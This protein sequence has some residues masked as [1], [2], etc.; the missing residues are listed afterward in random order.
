MRN[1]RKPFDKRT[2]RLVSRSV[3]SSLCRLALGSAITEFQIE[4]N[5]IK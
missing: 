2:L 5:G 4:L 1:V 3:S